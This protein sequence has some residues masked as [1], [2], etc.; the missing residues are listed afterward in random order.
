MP[1]LNSPEI[2]ST[3]HQTNMQPTKPVSETAVDPNAAEAALQQHVDQLLRDLMLPE[4]QDRLES[5]RFTGSTNRVYR[6]PLGEEGKEF[7]ILKLLPPAHVYYRKRMKRFLRNILYGEHYVSAGSKRVQLEISRCKEWR[8]NGL[9]VPQ[10]IEVS[11]PGARVFKGLPFPTFFTILS[12]PAIADDR[13]LEVLAAVVRSLALQHRIAFEKDR[14]GFVHGDPGP[15]NIMFDRDTMT[16]YWF[17]L[18]HPEHYPRM[19]VVDLMVRALRIFVYGVL[20][21]MEHRTDDVLTVV[22]QNYS[23]DF[24]LWRLIDDMQAKKSSLL[25]RAMET[26][27]LKKGRSDRRKRIATQLAQAIHARDLASGARNI[28]QGIYE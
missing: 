28:L 4:N 7:I 15:W 27:K 20:D 23:N 8:E 11:V 24:V 17:D 6:I 13:K 14:Q 5:F 10:A 2:V 25:I 9:S 18:E 22:A 21:H 12:N 3:I 19:T 26:M 1:E 16:T